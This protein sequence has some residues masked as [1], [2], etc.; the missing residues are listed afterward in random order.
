[1][2]ITQLKAT[3]ILG[4]LKCCLQTYCVLFGILQA[5]SAHRPEIIESIKL[6][7]N[8]ELSEIIIY[9]LKTPEKEEKR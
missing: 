4:R 9:S 2:S 3:V 8:Y 5:I 6:L 1:M 7:I